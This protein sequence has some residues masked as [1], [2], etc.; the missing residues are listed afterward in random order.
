[1]VRCVSFPWCVVSTDTDCH[2]TDHVTCDIHGQSSRL[3]RWLGPDGYTMCM[4]TLTRTCGGVTTNEGWQGQWCH[5]IRVTTTQQMTN[6]SIICILHS[7]REFHPEYS[8]ILCRGC[9]IE[10][11]HKMALKIALACFM[12]IASA[13]KEIIWHPINLLPKTLLHLRNF[14]NLKIT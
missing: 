13:F 8:S 5:I 14:K 1:M 12:F 10:S 3:S 9:L 6:M 2:D 7:S 4:M 11:L